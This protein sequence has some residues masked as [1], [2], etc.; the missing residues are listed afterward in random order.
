MITALTM[1]CVALIM[2]IIGGLLGTSGQ[3]RSDERLLLS[4]AKLTGNKEVM[5]FATSLTNEKV[6]K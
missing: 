3:R 1:A 4:S 6:F 5:E 2:F